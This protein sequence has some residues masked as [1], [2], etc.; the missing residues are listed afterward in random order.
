LDDKYI[1]EILRKGNEKALKMLYDKFFPS[2][3]SYAYNFV[4]DDMSAGDIVQEIYTKV[5]QKRKDFDS[6]YSIRSFFYLSVR[7]ACLN[8]I[9][10]N[11][12]YQ[13]VELNENIPIEENNF[14]IEEE[15]HRMIKDEI[16]KLPEAI[17][18]VFNFTLMD[19][20]ILEIAQAL[21]V[22]ENT[23]R[24]QRARAR[25]ILKEKLKDW[26]FLFFL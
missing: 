4:K 19:M 20:S 26:V 9:R 24:N 2:L 12:K 25:E 14:I 15:V 11:K 22:S 21:K 5:W 23:V 10:D 13:K 6:I 7:N 8:Y 1:V 17:R 18:K 16:E 3:C